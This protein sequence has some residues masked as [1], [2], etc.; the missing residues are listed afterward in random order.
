MAAYMRAIAEALLVGLVACLLSFAFG[1]MAG[2]C[3]AGT[4]QYVSFFG[5]LNPSLVIP[6]SKL[7][8][9]G[10]RYSSSMAGAWAGGQRAFV[11]S[12]LP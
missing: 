8:M 7:T 6:W 9:G 3:G 12:L 4:S 1:A 2:R 5:G 11:G 10:L